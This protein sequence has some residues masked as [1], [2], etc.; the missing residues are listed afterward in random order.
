MI[1][2]RQI[3]CYSNNVGV[4]L[5]SYATICLDDVKSN[6]LSVLLLLLSIIVYKLWLLIIENGTSSLPTAL[7]TTLIIA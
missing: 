4:N 5:I 6:T 2:F 7:Y 3:Q 1:R